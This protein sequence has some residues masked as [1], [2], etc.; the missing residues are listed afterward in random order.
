MAPRVKR[1]KQVVSAS[2]NLGAMTI[3][4]PSDAMGFRPPALG[5]LQ[6]W[7]PDPL[8]IE[9]AGGESATSRGSDDLHIRQWINISGF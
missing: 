6:Q 7:R 3:Q 1:M 8:V 5:F 9:A 2:S 4:A